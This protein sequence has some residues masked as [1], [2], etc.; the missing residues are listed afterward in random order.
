MW[1]RLLPPFGDGKTWHEIFLPEGAGVK[2][3]IDGLVEANSCL[4]PYLRSTIEETFHQLILL[5]QDHVLSAD[6]P[7][8]PKDRI[9]VV[10]PLTGG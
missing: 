2:E 1:V 6:D 9:V 10:M 5:R 7:L 4:K 3:L 8:D